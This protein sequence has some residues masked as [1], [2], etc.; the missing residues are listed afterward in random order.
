[1][2]APVAPS[3]TLI[4]IAGGTAS[5]K[6][7][8]AHRIVDALPAGQ[9]ALIQ[10]DAYYRDRSALTP[11]QRALLNF[12]EPEALEND[13][14]LEHLRALKR[15]EA[16]DCPEYDFTTHTR[17]RSVRRIDPCAVVV[18]EGI[19]LLAVPALREI[20]DLRLYVDTEDDVRLVRRIKRDMFERG[21]D[22]S[23]IEAQFMGTVRAMHRQHVE[24]SKR[25]AHLIIPEGGENFQAL[26]VIVGRL[27]YGMLPR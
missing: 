10:H 16:V 21:R 13:L 2:T 5:G 15:G 24:P 6:T 1:M 17:K 9:A 20:F 19:L 26:D 25:Y 11:A 8:V 3:L 23:S 7:T 22:I 14:L 12:D 18:V 4:G 27:L